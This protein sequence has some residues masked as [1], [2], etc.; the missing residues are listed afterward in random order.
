MSLHSEGIAW[1][2]IA[3]NILFQNR[4]ISVKSRFQGK[5]TLVSDVTG[6]SNTVYIY[7]NTV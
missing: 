7:Q 6:Y 5:A 2:V 1:A 3:R 4:Q